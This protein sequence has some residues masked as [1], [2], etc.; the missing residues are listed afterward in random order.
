MYHLGFDPGA[1]GAVAAIETFGGTAS[2]RSISVYSITSYINVIKQSIDNAC[3][4]RFCHA[5]V[6]DVHAMPK[7]GVTSM[8]SFGHNKGIIEGMLLMAGIDFS[9]VSPQTWKREFGLIFP[10]GTDKCVIKC[11]SIKMAHTLFPEAVLRPTSRC[12]VD[13]DGMAEALLMAEYSRRYFNNV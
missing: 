1:S 3:G 12:R 7:Q 10:K 2:V 6:E 8:F 4:K 11:A 9:L 5:V 13:S